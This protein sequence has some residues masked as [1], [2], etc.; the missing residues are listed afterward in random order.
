[1]S[2][3]LNYLK[4]VVVIDV[5]MIS[6]LIK[7]NEIDISDEGLKYYEETRIMKLK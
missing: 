4:K 5:H 6:S 7:K 1:M 2:Q 3:L